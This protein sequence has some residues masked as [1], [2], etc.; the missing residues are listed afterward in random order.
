MTDKI[1]IAVGLSANSVKWKN[2][3]ITWPE[4]ED[5]LRLEHKTSETFAEY[6]SATKME[7]GKIKDVGGYV[8]GYL[9]GGRR[10][11]E[12]LMFRQIVTLDIDFAHINFWD[13]FIL[14]YDVAA[15]LHSTHKHCET[16]PRFRLVLPL[17]REVTPDEYVAIARKIAGNMDIELFDQ[18]TFEIHRLMFWQSSPKDVDYYFR[19]QKGEF[20]DADSVLAEYID[21]TDSS[22]WPT[23]KREY[24]HVRNNVSKQ[25]DPETKKG[26]VGAFCR[27]YSLDEAIEVFL[28]DEYSGAGTDRYTFKGGSTNGGLVVYDNK[29]AYSHHGSDPSGGKLCNSFDIVRIH[30]YGHLDTKQENTTEKSKSFIAMEEFIRED[31]KVKLLIASE[32]L[33]DSR[34]DFA[35]DLESE[36]DNIDWMMDLE[37]DRRNKYLPT[38]PNLKLIFDND[39]R[40]KNLLKLNMFDDKRYIYGN[41]PWRRVPKP[42]P[43]RNVDYAGIRAYVETIY[44]IVSGSKIDDAIALVFEKNAFHPIKDYLASVKWDG[45]KRIDTL[46]IDY[47]GTEDNAYTRESIRKMLVAAVARIYEPGVKYDEMLI[48]VGGQGCGKSTFLKKLGRKWFSDTFIS[49]QGK[50]ALEQIQGA[51]IIEMAELA[52][53]RKAEV[54]SIKHFIAKQEDTFRPAYAR[55]PETFYRQCV[56]FG[57]TNSEEFLRDPTG[58][59]RFYPIA[60]IPEDAMFCPK[61]GLPPEEIDLIWAEAV[62]LYKAKESLILS[63]EANDIAEGEQRKHSEVDERKGLV[64]DY[65]DRLYPTNWDDKDISDRR[66]WLEDI[67]SEKGTIIR[68][69]V[70]IAEI[71]SECWGKNKED[72]SRYL[73]KDINDIMRGMEGWKGSNST[74]NFKHYGKQKYYYRERKSTGEEV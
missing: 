64:V 69:F 25:A 66:I 65:L 62:A 39:P 74:K 38:A 11:I 54:E 72:M 9:R 6:M 21:W 53:I 50:E 43:I 42:E 28:K 19:S 61:F 3:E 27:S 56:F 7:Q 52:G 47:F 20:L 46:L 8:G 45:K 73:T 63:K 12:N 15:V 14:Q 17:N 5:K 70:C 34:Y 10:K 51:W 59:R 22:L 57:T 71:W 1:N 35:E 67:L 18:T 26:I 55:T 13:D 23:A 40:L 37:V 60:C 24:D 32:N 29:F 48:L 16:S 41:L 68:D 33:A 2:T 36:D 58:N 30:K 44:G 49:V 4:L 31:R